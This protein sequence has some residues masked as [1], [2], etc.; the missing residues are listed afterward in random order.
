MATGA[1][2]FAKGRTR[3]GQRYENVLVPKNAA[4]Y[5]GPWDCAEF[6]SWCVYQVSGRL[7]GC[8]NDNANPATVEAYTGAWWT[9]AHTIGHIVSLSEGINTVGAL[10][11]RKPP[12][13][14]A[15]G[16]IGISDGQGHTVEARGHAYGVC[17][18][19]AA[20]RDWDVAIKIPWITYGGTQ[21]AIQ[22]TPPS[23]IFKP[24]S[25]AGTNADVK[26]IQEALKA[27]GLDPGSIDGVYGDRTA[28]AVSNFQRRFGI[29]Q[30]GIVG[31]I[32]WSLLFD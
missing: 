2:L 17:T 26:L 19:P 14:G 29:S 6:V 15:M 18:A 12:S 24:G 25:P 7:Y 30:D 20:G 4:N 13:P 32:T 21:G 9:D 11:L 23:R 1:E 10:L 8:I 31:P 16:H 27:I 3:I 28:L 22:H 5:Q